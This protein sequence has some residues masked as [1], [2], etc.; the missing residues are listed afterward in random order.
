MCQH[1]V[2]VRFVSWY[3]DGIEKCVCGGG[4]HLHGQLLPDVS[5]ALFSTAKKIKRPILMG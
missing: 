5:K 3:G 4:R 2:I 1:M